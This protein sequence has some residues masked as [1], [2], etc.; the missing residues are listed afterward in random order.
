ME[1]PQTPPEDYLAYLLREMEQLPIRADQIKKAA[2]QLEADTQT[3][4]AS[5]ISYQQFLRSRGRE[6]LVLGQL[7]LGTKPVS[8]TKVEVSEPLPRQ[9]VGPKRQTLLEAIATNSAEFGSATTAQ[10]R[11]STGFNAAYV[12]TVVWEDTKR[13]VVGRFNDGY[14]LTQKGYELL[15]AIGSPLGDSK[16]AET[17][18]PNDLLDRPA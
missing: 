1:N 15:R 7:L 3:L 8:K 4:T 11:A 5:A 9:R 6:S 10:L 18:M 17:K 2:E 16:P 13:G 14:R 12:S